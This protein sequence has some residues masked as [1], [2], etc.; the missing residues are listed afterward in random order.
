SAA[1][2]LLLFA[3]AQRHHEWRRDAGPM[4]SDLGATTMLIIGVGA[5]GTALAARARAFGITTIGIDAKPD[6]VEAELDELHGPSA[7]AEQLPRA[8]WVVLTVPYT[9]ETHHLIGVE[10]LRAMRPSAYLVSVGRGGP[11][12][13]EALGPARDAGAIAGAALDVFATEPTP[14]LCSLFDLCGRKGFKPRGGRWR[15]SRE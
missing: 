3:T 2:A 5:V 1:R 13:H 8:D 10:Q 6:I 9:P 7:L 4:I 14:E 12:D 15:R 11:V